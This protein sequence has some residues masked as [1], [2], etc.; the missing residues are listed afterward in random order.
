MNS[1]CKCVSFR[2][3]F[4]LIYSHI[5]QLYFVMLLHKPFLMICGGCEGGHKGYPFHL[6]RRL[7][8]PRSPCRRSHQGIRSK[9]GFQSREA[10]PIRPPASA[11]VSSFNKIHIRFRVY[12]GHP[13]N[14]PS[15]AMRP[16]ISNTHNYYR[17]DRLSRMLYFVGT[18]CLSV[19]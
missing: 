19:V 1:S 16:H 4:G 6:R 10:I 15:V 7:C 8:R 17:D 11:V 5:D 3:Q 13:L 14:K 2:V 9:P 18:R 12:V